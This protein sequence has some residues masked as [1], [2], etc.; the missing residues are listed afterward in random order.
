MSGKDGIIRNFTRAGFIRVTRKEVTK[1]EDHPVI[2]VRSDT[3]NYIG[4]REG[5]VFL[6]LDRFAIVI[7]E[8]MEEVSTSLLNSSGE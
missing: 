1:K 7:K 8:N 4:F 6:S 5:Y 2:F 3:I